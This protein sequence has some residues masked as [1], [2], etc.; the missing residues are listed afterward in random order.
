MKQLNNSDS[1]VKRISRPT[2]VLQ[3]GE[4]NFL[5]AFVDWI[6]DTANEK[7]VIDTS[8]AVVSPRFKYNPTIQ[9]LEKQDCLYNVCLEG[10][11]NGTPKKETRLITVIDKAFSPNENPDLYTSLI[12]SPEL[13]FVVS[14]TTEQGIKYD[15]D[16][17]TKLCAATFPGKVTALLNHRYKH[18]NGD[19]DKGLIFLCCELSENN[20]ARLKEYIAKH[21]ENAGMGKEFLDWVDD[22]CIFCDTLVDRIVSGYSEDSVKEIEKEKGYTDNALVKGEL[23]HLWV[24]GGDGAEKVKEELPL[25]KAGLNVY[26]LPS[27]KEFRDKKV[28][29]LNGAHTGMVALSILAGNDTVFEAFSDTEINKFVNRF[30]EEEV[31]PVIDEDPEELKKFSAEILERFTNPYINHQLRSIALNSL[32]KWETRNYPTL[33]D[34]WTKQNKLADLSVFTLAALLAMYAPD[35]PF[36]PEDNPEHV[37]FIKDNWNDKD[38]KSTVAAILDS[39]IFTVNFGKEIPGL[40]EKTTEYLT[41]I[42]KDGIRKALATVLAK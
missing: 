15:D 33:K 26:F 40:L 19:K 27:V 38:L 31:I 2:K 23:Y 11:E 21:A 1:E 4:G 24:I 3:F 42:R 28:R 12:E 17:A 35:S 6:L 18:F 20:A 9:N 8:V 7:G 16:D 5:R 41:S 32:S 14:N 25:D 10:V 37:K 36:T 29:I 30:I 22:S 13:R 34:N 39:D